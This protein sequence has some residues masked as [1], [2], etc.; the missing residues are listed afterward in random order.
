MAIAFWMLA[1]AVL[2]GLTI[3]S[4]R[5]LR[6]RLLGG[7]LVGSDAAPDPA[8]VARITRATIDAESGKGLG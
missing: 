4:R 6:R 8:R 5:R 1:F 3:Y 7:A 2:V